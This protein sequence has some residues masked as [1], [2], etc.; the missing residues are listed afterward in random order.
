MDTGKAATYRQR[1][2]Q[3][4]LRHTLWAS[5]VVPDGRDR[6]CFDATLEEVLHL[7]SD[8]GYG[9]AYPATFG[10]RVGS[11]LADAMDIARG[12]RF[13]RVPEQYPEEAWYTYDVSCEYG[14]QTF[15]VPAPARV[16]AGGHAHGQ[17]ATAGRRCPAAA[18]AG[19]AAGSAGLRRRAVTTPSS[20]RRRR[21][22]RRYCMRM[23]MRP[24]TASRWC[25]TPPTTSAAKTRCCLRRP[26]AIAS[27]FRW[28]AATPLGQER[29][30]GWPDYS[31]RRAAGHRRR[32]TLP[33]LIPGRHPAGAASTR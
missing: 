31:G 7:I 19:A 30:G 13:R 27:S 32:A 1:H 29:T 11:E 3:I 25:R 26:L 23:G 8:V 33:T 17:R 22:G 10:E 6:G 18:P 12:G 24:V 5:D 15:A 21:Y 16:A 4:L 9:N 14:C 20:C 28:M 2:A